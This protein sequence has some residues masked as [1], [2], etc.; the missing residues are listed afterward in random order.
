MKKKVG[1]V[2]LALVLC[3]SIVG[4]SGTE[5]ISIGA[6]PQDPSVE[7][8]TRMVEGYQDGAKEMGVELDVQ[9]S[10]NNVEEE[11]RLTEAFISQGSSGVI[12]NPIDS[13]AIAGPIQ[14]AKN[15]GKHIVLTDVTPEDDP[16]ATAIVTSDNYS[17]GKAAGEMMM[18]MLPDGGKIIMTKFK[19][20]SIAM[21]DRYNG[22]QDAIAGSNIEI[23]DTID[24]DGTRE[25]TLA[26]IT[27]M[28]SKYPDLAGIFCSQ[29]DPAIG[30]L[31]AVDAANMSDQ[32]TILSY[33]VESEVAEA[34]KQGSAIKGGVTQFPYV[35]GY[36]AVRQT[37]RAIRGEEYEKLIEL[38][39]LPVT[40]DN[41]QELI[42]DQ[43]EFLKKYGGYD[44]AAGK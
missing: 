36:E 24:V 16:G 27:P 43:A 22:F 34:I 21:D 32:V 1:L 14:K 33:D 11:T 5:T 3:L 10:N 41:V 39:V 20:S 19:F 9:Y 25:D 18:E 26:K 44:L 2:F 35:M 42:D 8:Y 15:A 28:L 12:V 40:K 4:C 31:A 13:V 29:G 38:P 23:V 17:G 6:I 37:V 7:F 30:C